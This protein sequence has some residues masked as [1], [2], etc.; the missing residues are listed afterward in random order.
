MKRALFLAAVSAIALLSTARLAA[1]ESAKPPQQTAAAQGSEEITRA[2]L[3]ADLVEAQAAFGTRPD[4]SAARLSLAR[5][6]LQV[7]EFW[8]AR[9]VIAPLVS[10]RR[11]EPEVLELASRLAYMLGRDSEAER[12]YLELLGIA[13]GDQPRQRAAQEGLLRVYYQ[14]NRYQEIRGSL[15]LPE[16]TVYQLASAFEADPYQKEWQ[17]EI[18]E[19]EV[20]LVMTDPLPVLTIEVNRVPVV[21]FLDTGGDMLIL[22]PEIAEALQIEPVAAREG[23]FAGGHRAQVQHGVVD[24]VS[25]GRVAL[26]N[27]PVSI[28]PTKRFSRGFDGGSV[29]IGGIL[30]TS[31]LRQFLTTI[32]YAEE[33]VIFRER[34]EKGA[35]AFREA[36]AGQKATEVPFALDRYH[37][38]LARGVLDS[39]ENL[40]FFVDS[41]LNSDACCVAPIQTLQYLGIPVPEQDE[42][43]VGGGQGE[44]TSGTFPIARISLGPLARENLEGI[45]GPMPPQLFLGFGYA[46][47][48]MVSHRYLRQFTTWTIDFD[49]MTFTFTE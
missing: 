46:L 4:D 22:D 45:Y 42:V 31:I 35:A 11:A 43:G 38:M 24:R 34:S 41:G 2:E 20:L 6:L 9:E 15:S 27:V 23:T 37:V 21:V 18:R 8:K 13:D 14:T 7:G 39:G 47:D 16:N 40:T 30:G 3:L 36:V 28:L 44:V 29:T 10:A 5:Q 25:L 26:R 1:L 12:L 19:S 33:R 17:D 32:D 49:A 48:G